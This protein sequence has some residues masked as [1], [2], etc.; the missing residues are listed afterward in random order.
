MFT[1]S[2]ILPT[3]LKKKLKLILISVWVENLQNSALNNLD[4]NG[5]SKISEFLKNLMEFFPL[6]YVSTW[7]VTYFKSWLTIRPFHLVESNPISSELLIKELSTTKSTIAAIS[8]L[9][10]VLERFLLQ[11]WPDQ[12]QAQ[13]PLRS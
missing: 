11:F 5:R 13:N 10:I 9:K 6:D 3:N 7:Q 2:S 4:K 8:S 12:S 1:S